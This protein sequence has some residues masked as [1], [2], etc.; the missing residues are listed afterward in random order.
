MSV[1]NYGAVMH[2]LQGFIASEF[3]LARSHQGLSYFPQLIQL[4]ASDASLAE[5]N[6]R[7]TA[8]RFFDG[9]NDVDV[10]AGAVRLLGIV[11]DNTEAASNALVIYET[12]TVTEGTTDIELYLELDASEARAIVIPGGLPLAA[13]SWSA[14]DG[15]NA[16]M[17]AGTL[18]AANSLKVMLVY[19]E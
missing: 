7:V 2:Q 10:E 6:L 9:T 15:G 18:S 11:V 13:L 16:A 8:P 12:N 1:G 14:T 19:A 17:E 5:A 3:A 4:V